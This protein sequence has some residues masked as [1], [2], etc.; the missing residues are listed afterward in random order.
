MAWALRALAYLGLA[1]ELVLVALVVVVLV[2]VEVDV[3]E[4]VLVEVD[5]VEVLQIPQVTGQ[6]ISTR[7]TCPHS[8]T[9]IM[10]PLW[11]SA[12]KWRWQPGGSITPLQDLVEEL[13]VVVEVVVEVEVELVVVASC[14][15]IQ[16]SRHC[17]PCC[18][19]SEDD[20]C[21]ARKL[22]ASS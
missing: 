1:V 18:P 2:V 22:R 21:G 8:P 14:S 6:W 9:E 13:V 5:V 19:K 11:H 20:M 12:A 7:S 17:D 16:M 4:T 15:C 10:C 3:L